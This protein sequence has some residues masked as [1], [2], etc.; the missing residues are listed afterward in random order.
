MLVVKY[1]ESVGLP[2]ERE[3]GQGY[4]G[5]SVVSSRLGVQKSFADLAV[6][7]PFV[8]CTNHNLN[9]VINDTVEATIRSQI[10]LEQ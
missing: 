4:D 3:R 1:L 7:I 6:P 10:F 5:A 2:L 8:H 9:L